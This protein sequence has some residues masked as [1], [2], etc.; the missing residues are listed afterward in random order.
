MS[1]SVVFL[2]LT[3]LM[4]MANATSRHSQPWLGRWESSDENPP[5][6]EKAIM[7]AMDLANPLFSGNPK[8][9]LEFIRD[10]DNYTCIFE[11]P[12]IKFTR[13]FHFRMHEE[14]TRLLVLFN[15]RRIQHTW[16]EDGDKLL[17]KSKVPVRNTTI[18]TY[19]SYEV[20]GNE[21]IK[22]YNLAGVEGFRRFIRA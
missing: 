14:G 15:N 18:T 7:E 6:N 5:S 13:I 12:S 8:A 22:H 4:A 19:N 21:L 11:I 2:A 1:G 16:S 3:V 9:F 20:T 17:I 10:A